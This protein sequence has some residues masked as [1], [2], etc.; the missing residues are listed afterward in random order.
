MKAFF[1]Y[2]FYFKI[3]KNILLL[4]LSI[5]SSLYSQIPVKLVIQPHTGITWRKNYEYNYG[6]QW[7]AV[8]S[9]KP[10]VFYGLALGSNMGRIGVNFEKR[11]Q[12][13]SIK[14]ETDFFGYT[15]YDN[16]FAVVNRIRLDYYFIR[17]KHILGNIEFAYALPVRSW[18]YRGNQYEID[19]RGTKTDHGF[20]YYL[21]SSAYFA[22]LKV[23]YQSESEKIRLG[24][25]LGTEILRKK[26]AKSFDDYSSWFEESNLVYYMGGI[27]LAY[28]WDMKV[29]KKKN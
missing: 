16:A 11:G 2:L 24:M 29:K 28:V 12:S 5:N 18:R 4:I 10:S 23:T 7:L 22:G 14:K 19:S 15:I 27:N 13:I 6:D 25:S 21:R 1:R 8:S 3:N 26:R 9:F 20:Y 17:K